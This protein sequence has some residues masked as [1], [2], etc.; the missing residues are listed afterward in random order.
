MSV[1]LPIDSPSIRVDPGARPSRSTLRATTSALP[2]GGAGGQ[3]YVVGID[4]HAVVL[5]GPEEARQY[6]FGLLWSVPACLF[7]SGLMSLL[8]AF[9]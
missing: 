1:A 7:A 2:P 9:A 5:S 8:G 3:V 6:A 4:C